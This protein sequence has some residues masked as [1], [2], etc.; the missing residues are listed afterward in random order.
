[1]AGIQLKVSPAELTG[2]SAEI[3][4]LIGKISRQYDMLKTTSEASIGYWEGDA[5]DAFRKY[6][7]SIDGDMQSVLKR[8]GEH[9]ADLLKMAGVYNQNEAEIQEKV[10]TLP[11]EVIS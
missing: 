2:K 6:V 10:S 11:T 7:K 9:P 1:M 4:D 3:T 8:L 5:A